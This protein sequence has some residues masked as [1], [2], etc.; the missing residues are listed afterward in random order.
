MLTEI[1]ATA[2]ATYLVVNGPGSSSGYLDHGYET[3]W[4]M[5]CAKL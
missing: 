4:E 3:T 2:V 1:Q 5:A